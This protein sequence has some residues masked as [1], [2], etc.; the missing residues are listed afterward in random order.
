MFSKDLLSRGGGGEGRGGAVKGSS[1][2]CREEEEEEDPL[3]ETLT[4]ESSLYP[5]SLQ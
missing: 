1:N 3:E 4:A 5:N 2:F